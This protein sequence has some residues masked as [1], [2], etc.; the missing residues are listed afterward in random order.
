MTVHS[1]IRDGLAGGR[2]RPNEGPRLWIPGELTTT[3]KLPALPV[4]DSV[5]LDRRDG[6]RNLQDVEPEQLGRRPRVSAA[7][8]VRAASDEG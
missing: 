7:G 3:E 4:E 5:D 8:N 1:R 6:S 2:H